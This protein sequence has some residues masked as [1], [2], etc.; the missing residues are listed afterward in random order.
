MSVFC[1][2]ASQLLSSPIPK[3]KCAG[4]WSPLNQKHAVYWHKVASWSY[5]VV[6]SAIV[7]DYYLPVLASLQLLQTSNYRE[8]FL[9]ILS[10]LPDHAP[11]YFIYINLQLLHTIYLCFVLPNLL[12]GNSFCHTVHISLLS[13]SYNITIPPKHISTLSSRFFS[14]PLKFRNTFFTRSILISQQL[15]GN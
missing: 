7:K 3:V 6:L 8:G 5:P 9:E 10:M 15:D 12:P 2:S 4:H 1:K 13:H 11:I 14:T